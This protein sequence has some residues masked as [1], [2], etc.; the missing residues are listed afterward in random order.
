MKDL[1]DSDLTSNVTY[2]KKGDTKKV[3]TQSLLCKTVNG[4]K[5]KIIS[6]IHL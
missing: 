3:Q 1:L 4:F 5:G 6:E 2:W